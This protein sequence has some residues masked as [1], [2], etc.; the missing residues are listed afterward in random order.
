MPFLPTCFNKSHGGAYPH[1][2]SST[3]L[4]PICVQFAWESPVDDKDFIDA[5]QAS[6][7]TILKTAIADGQDVGGKKQIRYPN[8]ALQNTPLS[9]MYGDNVARL[10]RIRT[11]WDPENVMYLTGGFKF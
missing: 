11:A 2:P 8:Y 5:V 4:L 6:A 9:E 1:V 7:E 3:P 10:Q